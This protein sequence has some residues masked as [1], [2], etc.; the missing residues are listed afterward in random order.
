[1]PPTK[2]TLRPDELATLIRS[3]GIQQGEIALATAVTQPHVSRIISGAVS[4]RSKAYQRICE[5][6]LKRN[7]PVTFDHVVNNKDIVEAIASIW[8]G[9]ETQARALGSV[10]R[11]LAPLMSVHKKDLVP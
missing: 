8:D 3:R 6:V 9:S 10:I 1:M 4:T 11:S 7:H 2:P 5:Y